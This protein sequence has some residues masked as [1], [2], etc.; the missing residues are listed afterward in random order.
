MAA[1]SGE[2][3]DYRRLSHLTGC[4]F[5]DS[6]CGFHLCKLEVWA[7]LPITSRHFEIESE[8]LIQFAR[9]GHAIHF[10]PLQVIYKEEHSKINPFSDSIRWL[11]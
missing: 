7:T 5:A 2:P 11:C 4:Q 9:A 3:L 1:A 6:Q 8:L 10:V